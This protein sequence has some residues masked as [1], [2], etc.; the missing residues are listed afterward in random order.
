MEDIKEKHQVLN[1]QVMQSLIGD[2]PQS[3]KE[4][5]L[6]FL[7]QAADSCKLI[8]QQFNAGKLKA[9]KESSHFLKT[10]AKAIGAEQAAYLLQSL[11]N[12]CL[13]DD[14]L[15]CRAL[16]LEVKKALVQVRGEILNAS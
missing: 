9:I 7:K 12:A 1:R 8:A 15:K 4:F 3:I 16:I 14:R 13:E 10:S 2:D 5:E 6:D 11:E